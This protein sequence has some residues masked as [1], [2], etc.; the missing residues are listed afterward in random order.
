[1]LEN[2]LWQGINSSFYPIPL[3]GWRSLSLSTKWLSSLLFHP[4]FPPILHT[5]AWVRES[6]TSEEREENSRKRRETN[7]E[8]RGWEWGGVKTVG[9]MSWSISERNLRRC[10][11][12]LLPWCTRCQN[13][14]WIHQSPDGA[15]VLAVLY[16]SLI[17]SY[18]RAAKNYI[19]PR[20]TAVMLAEPP[21]VYFVHNSIIH[22]EL[23]LHYISS[24]TNWAQTQK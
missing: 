23:K 21:G 8:R 10:N 20:T 17:V 6:D 24:S 1:M 18:S 9:E 4:R 19:V 3:T 2:T 16:R 12:A 5:R 15:G 11:L 7:S 13:G 14:S 22:V